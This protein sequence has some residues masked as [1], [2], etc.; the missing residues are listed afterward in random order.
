MKFNYELE[1]KLKKEELLQTINRYDSSLKSMTTIVVSLITL[2]FTVKNPMIISLN[3]LIILLWGNKVFLWRDLMAQHA[4]YTIVFLENNDSKMHWET[5][6]HL[7]INKSQKSEDINTNKDNEIILL[8]IITWI[9]ILL[10]YIYS[11]ISELSNKISSIT[12]S[13]IQER[14]KPIDY[15]LI[16]FST[17]FMIILIISFSRKKSIHQMRE[18]WI[19]KYQ[20]IKLEL[21]FIL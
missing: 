6:N 15:F 20:S 8:I 13:A 9:S 19:A 17:F 21:P 3:Y 18:Q 11:T 7:L 4:A 12:I 2:G 5:I 10:L 1:C 14:L 16:G